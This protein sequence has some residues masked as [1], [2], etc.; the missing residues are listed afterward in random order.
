MRNDYRKI[1]IIIVVIVL[2]IPV[3]SCKGETDSDILIKDNKNAPASR[4]KII[5]FIDDFAMAVKKQDKERFLSYFSKNGI[6][7]DP[8]GIT[9]FK[10]GGEKGSFDLDAFYEANIAGS[11]VTL[12]SKEDII[13]GMDVIRDAVVKTKL[14]KDVLLEIDSYSFYQLTREKGKVKM[15]YL[16]AYWE[17]DGMLTKVFSHGFKGLVIATVLSWDMLTNQG[18]GGATGMMNSIYSIGGD[19]KEAVNSFVKSLNNKDNSGLISLFNDENSKIKYLESKKTYS[20]K[21]YTEG[22]A[23]YTTISVSSLR[24][25]G[26]NTACRF[27]LKEKGRKRHGVAIFQFS[28]ETEKIL[29]I[30]FY[31]N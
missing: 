2:G 10:R 12:V 14:D 26:W 20:P 16:R 15:D 31:W 22:P 30:R 4:A 23:K 24:S 7:E 29:E 17:M 1:I 19:G 25:A 21:S 6:A 11:D 9:P 28:P 27:N 18:L 8:A 5:E 13:C 3:L